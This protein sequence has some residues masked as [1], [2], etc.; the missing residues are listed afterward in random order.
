MFFDELEDV[1]KHLPKSLDKKLSVTLV[2]GVLGEFAG[3]CL[4]SV[5]NGVKNFKSK[6]RG[7][8]EFDFW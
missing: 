1:Q 5:L 7:C 3:T 2:A 6:P 4:V 8:K